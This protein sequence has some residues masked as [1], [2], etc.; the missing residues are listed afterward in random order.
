MVPS[1]WESGVSSKKMLAGVDGE[2]FIMLNVSYLHISVFCI[3]SSSFLQLLLREM[4][5]HI[6]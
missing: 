5:V 6:N 3:N 4:K 1:G 2:R